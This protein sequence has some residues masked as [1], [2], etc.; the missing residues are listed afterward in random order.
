MYANTMFTGKEVYL[1]TRDTPLRR[2][3][4]MWFSSVLGQYLKVHVSRAEAT[5]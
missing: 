5:W 3:A 2:A 1:C 4:G